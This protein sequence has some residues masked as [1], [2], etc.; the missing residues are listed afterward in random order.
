MGK[1]NQSTTNNG[2]VDDEDIEKYSTEFIISTL[3]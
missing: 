2:D 3:T 1:G